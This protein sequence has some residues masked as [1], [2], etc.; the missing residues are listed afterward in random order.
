[1]K[2]LL[3]IPLLVMLAGC[4]AHRYEASYPVCLKLAQENGKLI[5]WLAKN[6]RRVEAS[7][8]G[9]TDPEVADVLAR[10]RA[11]LHKRREAFCI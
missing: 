9:K 3:A 10:K 6:H 5:R 8:W 1:M 11:L 4:A 2:H 7:H